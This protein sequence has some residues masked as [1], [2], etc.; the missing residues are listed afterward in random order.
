MARVTGGARPGT[1][2]HSRFLRVWI[3]GPTV[4][5][6]PESMPSDN[7]VSSQLDFS[8]YPSIVGMINPSTGA[9]SNRVRRSANVQGTQICISESVTLRAH[10]HG[11]VASQIVGQRGRSLKTV[12]R[13]T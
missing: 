10:F 13:T 11:Q 6:L 9:G 7:D 2:M 8:M 5:G 3:E 12:F 4:S 1:P